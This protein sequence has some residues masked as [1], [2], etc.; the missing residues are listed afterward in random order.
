MEKL[1]ELASLQNQSEVVR[2]QDKIGEQN[3]HKY[4]KK[5]FEPVTDTTKITSEKLAK[6][7]TEFSINNNKALENL[8]NKHL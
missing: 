8:N 7:K 5:V 3:F 6:T 1:E 4:I 2:F